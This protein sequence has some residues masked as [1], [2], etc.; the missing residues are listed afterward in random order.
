MTLI[1]II[2]SSVQSS[3]FPLVQADKAVF[4][5]MHCGMFG[6]SAQIHQCLVYLVTAFIFLVQK[7]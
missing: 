4:F 2:L 7:S 5:W 3:P 6:T 1:N